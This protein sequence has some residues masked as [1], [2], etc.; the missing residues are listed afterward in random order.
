MKSLTSVVLLVLLTSQ[1]FGNTQKSKEVAITQ[2]NAAELKVAV[3]VYRSAYSTYPPLI[4]SEL[5]EALKGKKDDVNPKGLPFWS[6]KK[7][8]KILWWTVNHGVVNANGELI[9]GWGRPFYWNV[10]DDEQTLR[11]TSKGKDGILDAGKADGDDLYFTIVEPLK[12]RSIQ[13]Q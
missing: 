2:S 12:R 8:K 9:D 11:L 13:T 3:E 6:P 7:E 5:L 4:K 1:V 10:S